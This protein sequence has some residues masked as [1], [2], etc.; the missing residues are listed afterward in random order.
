MTKKVL[1][2]GK[3]N[4]L[5]RTRN[6]YLEW[7]AFTHHSINTIAVRKRYL[8]YFFTWCEERD[9]EDPTEI[10]KQILERY[11][12]YMYHYRKQNGKPLSISSQHSR[13][14]AIRGYFKY[15]AKNNL[16]LYN[17]SSEIT[18]PKIGVQL[19]KE[20]LTA[21]EM[22][23][24]LSLPNITTTIGLRDRAIM[25]TLYSTGIRR[26]ELANLDLYDIDLAREML[27]VREGKGRKDR[28]LPIGDTAL[29]WLNKY[30]HE[31][32]TYLSC[33]LNDNA[34]FLGAKGERLTKS[35]LGSLVR[36][37][38]N[39]SGTNKRGSCHLFR[40]TVATLMLENGADIR[41]VQQLLGHSKLES[42]KIYTH[43]SIKQL[44]AVHKLTHPSERPKR[45]RKPPPQKSE[46]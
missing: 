37:Y 30:I 29:K 23:E 28:Y 38:I 15:L 21:K 20:I 31:S 11:Q 8:E 16:I 36:K 2:E 42:T 25:E 9:L 27:L 18:S 43:V 32:R 7:M 39:K 46:D 13:L 1:I 26:A 45:K 12:K 14:V 24:I 6:V 10:T 22:E 35:H 44:R 3:E 34:L 41:Y 4:E 33:Q 5:H 19:P 40:H 17:P